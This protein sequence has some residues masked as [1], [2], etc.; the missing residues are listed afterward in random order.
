MNF[1]ITPTRIASAVAAA[2]LATSSISTFADDNE[3]ASGQALKTAE[4]EN[5]MIMSPVRIGGTVLQ[6]TA[7]GP[8]DGY[9]AKRSAT[10]SKTDISIIEIPQSISVVTA[11]RLETIG[12]TSLSE[13]L[14]YS[15]GINASPWGNES[16]YDW[17]YFRGFD[18]YSP[19]F[20]LDGMQQR[21]SGDT[22]WSVWQTEAYGMER[23]EYLRG[24]SSVLYGQNS[25]GGVV[26]IVS[27]R[28][29]AEPIRDIRVQLGSHGYKQ[30]ATDLSGSLDEGG[31]WLYRITAL[32]RDA[33]LSV[34]DDL[35]NDRIF[36]APALTWQPTDDTRLTLL[37]Q[38]LDMNVASNWSVFPAMGT[39]LPNP[40]GP[41]PTST[42]EGE[43]D[44]S[45]YDQEQWMVGSLFEH[46]INDVWAVRM[47]T[48]YGA[49]DTDY[50][51]FY[52]PSFVTVNESNPDAAENFRLMKR[53]PFASYESAKQF[54]MDNQVEAKLQVGSWQH[55]LLFGLDYQQTELDVT[56]TWGGTV[57]P[58]DAYNPVYGSAVTLGSS[59]THGDGTNKLQQTGIYIQDQI[60]FD[61]RWVITLGGRFDDA[62]IE[63]EDRSGNVIKQ[64]DNHFSGR[65][66]IVYLAENGLA[67]YLSYSESFNPSQTIDP[68]T[69]TIDPATQKVDPLS[70]QNFDP[71]TGR[72]YEIG[73]R[74]QP[75]G[76]NNS[77][78]IA[79]FD[80]AR[81][82][83]VTNDENWV[84]KSLGEV[85]VRGIELE[86][87]F[88][89]L[90]DMNVT[91]SYSWTPESGVTSSA[92]PNDIGKQ[93]DNYA[94]NQFSL[95]SD[96]TLSSGLK[97]GLGTRYTGATYGPKEV[98]ATK[99][100][101]YM[102]VD[103]LIG[104]E[105]GSW[106][107]AVNARNLTNDKFIA[108][109]NGRGSRFSYGETR[110]IM[111]T[112]NYGW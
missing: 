56:A 58:I 104:Y 91:A 29:T 4:N 39:L 81:K 23:L 96:Y 74:Y 98:V 14:S 35:P 63:S 40:N 30:I 93:W 83:Y 103:A 44:F 92:N 67:P 45:K 19:G 109:S 11:D 78:S 7:S 49:Y 73:L 50:Q 32:N 25:A 5:A 55:A 15:P 102:I 9:V 47:N 27:K 18:A 106:K 100:P 86:A 77:Y 61:E 84:P 21:V 16:Q 89:P 80:V 10:G 48:R 46:N 85:T 90:K 60:K 87:L 6:E 70:G 69:R 12:A 31:E 17:V 3:T 79:A 111:G 13:A 2:L 82:N 59:P 28:P 42:F 20:Y 75:L 52:S 36:V 76:T 51:T 72:Q 99:I 97:L 37:G 65:A 110:S 1:T 22:N 107:F 71:A 26:N 95:W 62:T 105:F 24:P 53:T 94:E 101:S 112:I 38:Y 64:A 8:V 57:A 54:T 33:E 88:S 41:I 68:A 34:G 108:N 43:P 66:G